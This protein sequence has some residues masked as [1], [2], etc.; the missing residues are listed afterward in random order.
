ME[1]YFWVLIGLGAVFLGVVKM[2]VFKKI[3]R[4]RNKEAEE[5]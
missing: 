4:Q 3:M 1:W 2:T 5:E